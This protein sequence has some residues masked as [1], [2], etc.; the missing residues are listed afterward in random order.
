MKLTSR[1]SS[2]VLAAACSLA[3][4]AA[5]PRPEYPRPQFERDQ[6]Q[7]LNG[8]WTYEF[9]KGKSGMDRRL[10]ESKGF[11]DEI[12]VPFCPESKLS[13]VEHTD[14][15][16][17]MWYHR[18]IQVPAEWLG[19]RIMLNFGGVDFFAAVYVDGKLVGRHW[20][21]SSPFSCDIT[22]L[23]ADGQPHDLVVRV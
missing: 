4:T 6:W 3:M 1:L 12:T 18:T 13:G 17:A 9:D 11:A 20:G 2:L 15:I 5:I 22:E 14:F 23:T 21:G 7:N 8:Q 19:R 16:P 10:F